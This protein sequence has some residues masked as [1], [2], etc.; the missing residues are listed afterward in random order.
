M[1]LIRGSDAVSYVQYTE[2]PLFL[3][4]RRD[5]RPAKER[6]VKIRNVICQHDH[7]DRTE[8]DGAGTFSEATVQLLVKRRR[9]K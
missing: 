7:E 4:A 9:Q 1:C 2:P 6:K 5:R 8:E 3:G